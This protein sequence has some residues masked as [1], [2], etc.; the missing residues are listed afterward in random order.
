MSPSHLVS[1]L[2]DQP[3]ISVEP[4]LVLDSVKRPLKVDIDGELRVCNHFVELVVRTVTV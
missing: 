4:L 2:T 3:L 1:T